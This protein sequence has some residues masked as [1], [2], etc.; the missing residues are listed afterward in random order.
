MDLSNLQAVLGDEPQ[1]RY[2]QI[3]QAV[4]KNLINDWDEATNLSLA[5]RDKL[6]K[7]VNLN[8]NS[9]ILESKDGSMKALITLGDGLKIETVLMPYDDGRRTVC[10][11]TQVG[12]PMGCLFCATG[13]M[14]YKRDLE[15]WEIV[16]QVIL[17]ARLLKKK[18]ERI[19]NIVF[20]G[21]G[22]PFLNYDNVL[23]AIYVLHDSEGYNMGARNFS[24]S[25][26]GVI[27]GINKLTKEKLDINLAISLHAPNNELRLKLIPSSKAYP[28][29]K[30]LL[31]VDN[32]LKEKNRKVMFEYI[33]LDGVNDSDDCAREL[34]K[35][36][37]RPLYHV[38]L[39]I[40]NKTGKY[41]P[42]SRNKLRQFMK[43]LETN[44][45]SVS[46]RYSFGSDIYA[47]CGQLANKES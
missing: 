27:E 21:M 23:K 7:E 44:K 34:A 15:K 11:S 19:S 43:I 26:V 39:M 25:T 9:K 40:Y 46:E 8:I 30:I 22:E 3:Y 6:K 45:V 20:M 31:A 5:L 1:Y 17:F 29:E 2:K 28:I 33:L 10:V 24:I 4:M 14:G 32:Y 13:Q 18:E 35:L 37:H 42:A 16:E 36:M 12:C 38:N 41:S 47:A